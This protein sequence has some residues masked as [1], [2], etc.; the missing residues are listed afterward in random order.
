M[1]SSRS[2]SDD[3]HIDRCPLLSYVSCSG[4]SSKTQKC[5]LLICR[6]PENI[7]FRSIHSWSDWFDHNAMLIDYDFSPYLKFCD[8]IGQLKIAHSIFKCFRCY[9]GYVMS[10]TREIRMGMQL[11]CTSYTIFVVSTHVFYFH[12]LHWWPVSVNTLMKAC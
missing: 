12:S 6:P 5:E 2:R 1:L 7:M 10:G 11:C 8:I 3:L 4:M 9:F